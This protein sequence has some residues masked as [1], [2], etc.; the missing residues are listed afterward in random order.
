MKFSD[1]YVHALGVLIHTSS[2]PL[3]IL[4]GLGT[5]PK[6][7]E[8]MSSIALTLKGLRGVPLVDKF[9]LAFSG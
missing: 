8:V 3:M 7:Y 5:I 6:D 1:V 4:V 2:P 9:L